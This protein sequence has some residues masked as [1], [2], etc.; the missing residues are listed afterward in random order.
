MWT[1]NEACS[2]FL[3]SCYGQHYRSIIISSPPEVLCR[4]R[5]IQRRQVTGFDILTAYHR[6]TF[7]EIRYLWVHV[8][9]APIDP[10]DPVIR[11]V[12]RRSQIRPF[13]MGDAADVDFKLHS[14]GR[15]Q[16]V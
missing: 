4:K 15:H 14:I 12:K 5:A 3:Q 7:L 6:T 11:M 2:H 10:V 9:H 16:P 13:D 8:G 1:G